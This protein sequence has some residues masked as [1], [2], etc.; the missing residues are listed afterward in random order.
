[1]DKIRK[2]L[3]DFDLDLKAKDKASPFIAVQG[4]IGEQGQRGHELAQWLADTFNKNF[5][6]YDRAVDAIFN[7]N[8]IGGSAYHHLLD[9]QHSVWGAFK[10]VQDVKIDD[11]WAQEL[12]QATEHLLRD[13]ASVSGINPFFTLSPE[14]FDSIGSLVSNIGISRAF[15]ADALTING[16]ELLGGSLALLSCIILGKKVEYERLS[17][18]SSGC[19]LSSLVYANPALMPIAAGSM[20]Y[21]IYKSKNKKEI[22]VQAGRGSIASG[23]FFLVSQLIGGPAWIGCVAGFLTA[24]AV[25][26]VIEKPDKA[27]EYTQRLIQPAKSIYKK[28]AYTLSA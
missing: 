9:G 17:Y 21:A 25:A 12:G 27:F 15:L 7:Q 2:K 18:I 16:A 23:S 8:H 13:T 14:Q 24:V 28:V 10:S 5:D 6:D 3:R 20:V 11:S 19:L 4:V 26:K 1:M 22:L